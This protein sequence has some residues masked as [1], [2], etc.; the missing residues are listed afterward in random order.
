MYQRYSALFTDLETRRI[1]PLRSSVPPMASLPLKELPCK[2]LQKRAVPS[3][4]APEASKERVSLCQKLA[5]RS[6]QT[7]MIAEKNWGATMA[8]LS[9]VHDVLVKCKKR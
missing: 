4:A 7:E 1:Y 3:P 2:E 5:K 6:L 9:F 8:H